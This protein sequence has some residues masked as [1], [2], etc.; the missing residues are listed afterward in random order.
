MLPRK[1]PR[2]EREIA[3]RGKYTARLGRRGSSAIAN[4]LFSSPQVSPPYPARLARQATSKPDGGL[5]SPKLRH[6]ELFRKPAW[7]VT[8]AADLLDSRRGSETWPTRLKDL[9]RAFKSPDLVAGLRRRR[10]GS[11]NGLCEKRVAKY[12]LFL[13]LPY[14]RRGG[15][16][17]QR[18]LVCCH[19]LLSHVVRVALI[20]AK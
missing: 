2:T 10:P 11:F 7:S 3:D 1:S 17:T 20:Y 18:A 16:K 5:L 6:F 19:V 8:K 4:G 12:R 15:K 13:S 14:R 9:P